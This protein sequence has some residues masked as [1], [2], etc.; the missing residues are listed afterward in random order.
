MSGPT[1]PESIRDAAAL[2]VAV[3]RMDKPGQQ[4]IVSNCDKP[5]TLLCLAGMFAMVL[6]ESTGVDDAGLIDVVQG[7]ATNIS[8]GVQG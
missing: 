3:V 8:K 4:A 5:E 2:I 7:F 6:Q 1:T